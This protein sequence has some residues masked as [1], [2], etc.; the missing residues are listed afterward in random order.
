LNQTKN[1]LLALAFVSMNFFA[2][3]RNSSSTVVR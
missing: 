1:G 3:P 2:A